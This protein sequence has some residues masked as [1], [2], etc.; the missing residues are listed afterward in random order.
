MPATLR[1]GGVLVMP[2]L[3]V[4][5]HRFGF[6]VS[7]KVMY[8]KHLLSIAAAR[9]SGDSVPS[10]DWYEEKWLKWDYESHNENLEI[11][12]QDKTVILKA[13]PYD[14]NGLP[15]LIKQKYFI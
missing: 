7:E 6:A 4:S 5:V 8:W 9:K 3:S 10:E 2:K 13:I 12:E 14:V 1:H 15:E 11:Q